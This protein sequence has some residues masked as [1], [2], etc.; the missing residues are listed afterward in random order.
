[1]QGGV[2]VFLRIAGEGFSIESVSGRK[3]KMEG[4]WLLH[5]SYIRDRDNSACDCKRGGINTQYARGGDGQPQRRYAWTRRAVAQRYGEI[6]YYG[7]MW[8]S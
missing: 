4:S 3:Q 1:V 7:W 8:A 6:N 5:S 2:L